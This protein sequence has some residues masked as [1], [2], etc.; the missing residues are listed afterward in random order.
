[1]LLPTFGTYESLR[2]TYITDG[3]VPVE[4]RGNFASA[5]LED[6]IPIGGV[7]HPCVGLVAGA[8]VGM[9][10]DVDRLQSVRHSHIT[11]IGA[12]VTNDFPVVAQSSNRWLLFAPNPV[13]SRDRYTLVEAQT[14]HRCRISPAARIQKPT[15]L[16]PRV[17]SYTDQLGISLNRRMWI[18]KD[19]HRPMGEADEDRQERVRN[20]ERR[21]NHT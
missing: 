20:R 21:Y 13:V 15:C 3:A 5:T 11:E 16:P 12:I 7:L 4:H 6:P 1:M 14:L 9:C 17:H 18:V 8:D 19:I 10:R 2:F